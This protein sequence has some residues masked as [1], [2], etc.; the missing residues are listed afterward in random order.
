MTFFTSKTTWSI[1][2]MFI[3]G[4]AEAVGWIPAATGTAILAIV[5]GWGLTVHN[6]QI[7]AGRVATDNE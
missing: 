3:I 1:I 7:V 4:G 5:A 6:T 2:V